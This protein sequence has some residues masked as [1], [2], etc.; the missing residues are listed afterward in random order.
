MFQSKPGI[1]NSAAFQVSGWPFITASHIT[2]SV[3]YV[4]VELPSVA[5][6]VT[7]NNVDGSN[8]WD[9][10]NG[11]TLT[12][13]TTLMVFFGKVLTGTYPAPQMLYNHAIAIPVSGSFTFDVKCSQVF[14]A[15]RSA[16]DFGAFQLIAELTNCDPVDLAYSSGS[17]NF[18]DGQ[19]TGS[20]VDW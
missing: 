9:A 15:K 16:N 7:V 20:G 3:G 11:Y 12:G 6:S 14:V 13:S 2:A 8:I 1:G 4:K 10:N 5:K 18:R 17:T 19:L